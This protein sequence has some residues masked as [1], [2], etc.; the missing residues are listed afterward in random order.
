MLRRLPVS[1][2]LSL[3][4]VTALAVMVAA[5][6]PA[7]QGGDPLPDV[8][9]YQ[10]RLTDGGAQADGSYDLRFIL[11]D[12]DVGGSQIGSI[13][14]REDVVV[15]DGYFTV[16]LDF[17]DGLF[18]GGERWLELAVR[19]GASEDAYTP[20]AP[21]QELTPTPY[22][23]LAESALGAPWLGLTGVPAGL[24]DGVDNDTVYTAGA[25][26][27]L[28]AQEFSVDFAGTGVADAAARSDHDHFGA[29]WSG[30]S[31][32]GL[33]IT[34][35][36]PAAA[37][38]GQQLDPDNMPA[39]PSGVLHTGILST[40]D[41]T[42][43]GVGVWGMSVENSWGVY[44]STDTGVGVRGE[45]YNGDGVG[46]QAWGQGATGVA[47][48]I[49]EGALRVRNAGLGT[50][51]PVFIHRATA[52]NTTNNY[53]LIDHPLING[54]PDAL[55]FVTQNWDA[56][57]APGVYNAHPVGVFYQN[58]SSQWAVFNEDAAAMPNGA[59]FNVL[60]VKP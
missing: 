7:P 11:Y 50:D 39:A 43:A 34:N 41:G 25:G 51:T 33:Q 6:G 52:E 56:A 22:A 29:S 47:L 48:M 2:V 55:L 42:G 16:Q 19:P 45:A 46:V 14:T 23:L 60:V 35:S 15:T 38:S 54:D 49:G 9:T 59:A 4:L 32:S 12:T 20:L 18:D 17:G 53:T 13:A 30:T 26:L 27:T 5:Q 10:G 36:G 31:I 21:R 8:F 3:L 37:Q 24:A 40:Y 28:S 44:G 57:G 1:F 58:G